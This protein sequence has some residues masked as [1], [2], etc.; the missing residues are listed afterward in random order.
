MANP[1]ALLFLAL[2][3]LLGAAFYGV[4]HTRAMLE[5]AA[6]W[7]RARYGPTFLSSERILDALGPTA[8]PKKAPSVTGGSRSPA[9][10]GRLCIRQ[11]R[12]GT[13][14]LKGVSPMRAGEVR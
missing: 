13:R 2:A 14:G 1:M 3:S 10:V 9:V 4:F 7:A 8:G 6:G 5:M 11:R 12:A